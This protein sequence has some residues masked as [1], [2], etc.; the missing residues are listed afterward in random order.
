MD[1]ILLAVDSKKS[2]SS[3]DVNQC[4]GFSCSH[5]SLRNLMK[6]HCNC[7]DQATIKM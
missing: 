3:D 7:A 1:V 5:I 4:V 2:P 6:I